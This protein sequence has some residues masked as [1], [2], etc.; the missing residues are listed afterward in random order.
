MVI[1]AVTL[2]A[3]LFAHPMRDPNRLRHR[4]A[5]SQIETFLAALER[6]K[7]DCRQYPS[8]LDGLDA[9]NA[10]PGVTGW[11]GPYIVQ[12]IPLDPWGRQY[13]YIYSPG[14]ATPEVQSYG[15]DGKPGGQFFD[16]DISSRKLKAVV[17]ES[18]VERRA[19]RILVGSTIGSC[20][21]LLAS[22]LLWGF[23]SRRAG[24]DG[25]ESI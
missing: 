13:H 7:A 11:R 1:C 25:G 17:A 20:I 3:G 9:L 4:H 22:F 24:D 21:G 2:L 23:A 12:D 15:A 8:N 14:E 5:V 18:P 10:N 16:A 6:Y 19:R